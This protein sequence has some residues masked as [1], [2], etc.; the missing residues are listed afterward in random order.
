[1]PP[2]LYSLSTL[3]HAESSSLRI[4]PAQAR[5]QACLRMYV[6]KLMQHQAAG[7]KQVAIAE[8]VTL[9]IAQS[10]KAWK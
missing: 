6:N 1:M 8:N 5:Q 9:Y 4:Q 3:P 2:R 10:S 7:S